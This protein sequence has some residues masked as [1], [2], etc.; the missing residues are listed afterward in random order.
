MLDNS[1]KPLF[2][3]VQR[4]RTGISNNMMELFLTLYA[5]VHIQMAVDNLFCMMLYF[6]PAPVDP[7]GEGA[8]AP[9][10]CVDPDEHNIR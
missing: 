8:S 9:E 2:L 5:L 4:P 7:E 6:S 1:R 10:G 3:M